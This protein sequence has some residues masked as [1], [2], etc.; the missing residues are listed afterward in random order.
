MNL[1]ERIHFCPFITRKVLVYLNFK[2]GILFASGEHCY[3][4]YVW[5]LR[6]DKRLT[7][8]RNQSQNF[9]QTTVKLSMHQR[10]RLWCLRKCLNS[11]CSVGLLIEF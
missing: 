11:E 9:K 10:V 7:K 3:R 2:L 5:Q 1:R 4:Y 6:N 8:P